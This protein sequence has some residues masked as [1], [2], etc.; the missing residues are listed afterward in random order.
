MLES[1][2]ERRGKSYHLSAGIYRRLGKKDAYIRQRGFEP[3]QR[4]QMVIQYVERHGSI[5]RMEVAGLCMLNGSQAY[6]LVH[7][8][9]GKGLLRK[10]KAR[11]RDVRYTKA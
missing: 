4:E 2:G 6:R 8:M 3:I 1:L 7:G 5:S 10:T 11:G 9:E